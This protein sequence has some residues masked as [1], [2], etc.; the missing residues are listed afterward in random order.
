[1]STQAESRLRAR[2]DRLEALGLSHPDDAYYGHDANLTGVG[3]LTKADARE[4][5]LQ[6]EV[7]ANDVVF[8]LDTTNPRCGQD[9][10]NLPK[11]ELGARVA[12]SGSLR[13]IGTRG[14]RLGRLT[15]L[16]CDAPFERVVFRPTIRANGLIRLDEGEIPDPDPTT[17]TFNLVSVMGVVAIIPVPEG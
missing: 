11:L 1:M 9:L 6:V 7:E 16:P 12:I 10:Y 2:K 3:V 8:Y 15:L 14:V 13:S 4:G 17:S 5:R